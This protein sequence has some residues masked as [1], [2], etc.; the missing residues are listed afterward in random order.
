LRSDETIA[1]NTPTPGP[2]GTFESLDGVLGNWCAIETGGAL[3]CFDR[4]NALPGFGPPPT[5]S[6]SE[7]S[8]GVSHAC[9]RAL[10][11]EVV[12]WGDDSLGQSTVPADL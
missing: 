2:S 11:G 6:F 7:L 9:A 3:L 8:Y 1:C 5:G 10:T 12:C 4:G